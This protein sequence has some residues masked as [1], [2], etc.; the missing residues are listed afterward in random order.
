MALFLLAAVPQ[1]IRGLIEDL[2][3]DAIAVREDAAARLAA[4]GLKAIPHLEKAAKDEDLEVAGRARV[5]IRRIRIRGKLTPR[6]LKALPGLDL[7]LIG[8]NDRTWTAVFWDAVKKSNEGM[9]GDRD[10]DAI[11]VPALRGAR[12]GTEKRGLCQVV[13]ARRLR[14]AVPEL[15]R[16]LKDSNGD[17]RAGACRALGEVDAKEAVGPILPVLGD[18][19]L[20]ARG[21]AAEALGLLRAGDA[22]PRLA[23][24]LGDPQSYVRARAA[25]ALRTLGPVSLPALEKALK[26]KDPDVRRRA[27][28]VRD[29][30]RFRQRR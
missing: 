8:G 10:L 23:D 29:L 17:V 7:R 18:P 27:S 3:S 24:L 5:L 21:E 2:G 30:I 6:L 19:Y 1:E 13:G 25:G 15:V 14:S 20:Y 12:L 16:L 22:A 9:L 4:L 28:D 11:I 26:H